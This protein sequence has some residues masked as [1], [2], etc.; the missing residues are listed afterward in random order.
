VL[1]VE[2]YHLPGEILRCWAGS[3]DDRILA[4]CLVRCTDPE[5]LPSLVEELTGLIDLELAGDG[6]DGRSREEEA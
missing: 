1:E 3:Y 6:G 2:P 5:L 4:A